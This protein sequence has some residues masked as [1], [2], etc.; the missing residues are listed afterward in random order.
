MDERAMHARL[1][2]VI[3]VYNEVRSVEAA[4]LRVRSVQLHL[5][6]IVVDD[7]STDGT[8]SILAELKNQG[9]IDT[10]VLHE[11]NQGK[12]A[13]VRTGLAHATSAVTVVQDADLEYD[14]HELPRLMEPILDGRADAVFGSRFLG[15][16]KRVLYFWHRVGNGMLTLL[17]NMLT[18]INLSDMETCYKMVR[19]DLLKS[20]PLSSQRFGIELELTARLAQAGARIYEVPISYSGRTYE[21]G[22]KINWK[23]GVAALWHILRC[24]LPSTKATRYVSEPLSDMRPTVRADGAFS[25]ISGELGSPYEVQDRPSPVQVLHQG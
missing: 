24:N 14:P 4:I 19:T 6:L 16:P 23:D 12:G 13:A 1:S 21:E 25:R 10:L 3:P 22:K 2:V 20:L 11:K 17:S 8:R 9:L 18:N 5:E 7:G 15:G